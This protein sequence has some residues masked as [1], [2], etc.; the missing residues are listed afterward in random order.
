QLA[1]VRQLLMIKADTYKENGE[2]DCALA[3]YH[4]IID[5]YRTIPPDKLLAETYKDLGDLYRMKQDIAEGLQALNHALDIYRNL[6]DELEISHTLNN[7]GNIYWIASDFDTALIQYRKSLR[8]KRRLKAI[9][10]VVTTLGNIAMIYGVKGRL[11]RSIRIMELCL[12]LNKERGD[13][14]S[15]ARTLNNLGYV[16]YYSGDL[17][18]A[19]CCLRESLDLNR[20]IGNK[21]EIMFNLENLTGVMTTAG[22]LKEVLPLLREGISLSE[23]LM[24]NRHMAA[25]NLNIGTVHKRMGQFSAADRYYEIGERIVHDIGDRMLQVDA[26]VRRASLRYFLGDTF[27]ARR[28][29]EEAYQEAEKINDKSARLSALLLITKVSSEPHFI[30]IAFH[31]AD[32]LHLHRERMLITVNLIESLLEQERQQDALVQAES[33][34][35]QLDNIAEDIELA[36]MCNIAAELMITR[37]EYVSAL[38]FLNRAYR[39]ATETG[40]MPELITTLTLRGKVDFL[41]GKFENCY[42]RYKSAL[43]ICRKIADNITNQTDRKLFENRRSVVFLLNEIKRLGKLMGQ[44]KDRA[45]ATVDPAQLQS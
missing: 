2:A 25:F 33:F 36:W 13:T 44:K 16:Y 41:N 45:F 28:L 27:E 19:V 29:A 39:S 43:Q 21:K 4:Q 32:E 17:P 9:A 5:L 40:L 37:G 20:R 24:D 38:T 23:R 22:H 3:T 11:K 10:D 30:E 34:I 42:Q 8:I 1:E 7:I 14:R 6:N 26:K 31:L 12:S 35:T 18:K 15:I